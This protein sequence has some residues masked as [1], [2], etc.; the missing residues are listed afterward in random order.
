MLGRVYRDIERQ[1]AKQ[2]ESIQAAFT[3][4]MALTK[5]LL[6]QLRHDKNKLYAL[7]APEVECIAKGKAHKRYEF[8]VKASFTTTNRSN[9][10]GERNH[11][12][13]APTMATHSVA[14]WRRSND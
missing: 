2:P 4:E 13:A 11:Y 5:R 3:A 14:H 10:V 9:L 8:G 6:D 12:Q 1:L 7:H